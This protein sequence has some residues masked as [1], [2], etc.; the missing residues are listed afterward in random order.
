MSNVSVPKRGTSVAIVVPSTGRPAGRPTA[1]QPRAH[2]ARVA[3]GFTTDL[4]E[5]SPD[6]RAHFA[7]SF[8]TRRRGKVHLWGSSGRTMTGSGIE[9]GATLTGK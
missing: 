8:T 5:K 6:V 7:E 9:R 2:P 3:D 1:R 4:R